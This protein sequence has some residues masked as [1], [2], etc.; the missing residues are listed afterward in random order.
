MRYNP[1]A[2]SRLRDAPIATTQ[3]G[4]FKYSKKGVASVDLSDPYHFAVSLT[5]PRFIALV[6]A[7]YLSLNLIFATTLWLIPGSVGNARPGYFPDYLFFSFETLATVGYGELYPQGDAGH[8]VA[9][10][11]IFC[12]IWFM[13]ILT[14]LVFVRFS[15]P[16]S[17]F[18]IARGPVICM[19][20]NG[21]ALM[22]RLANG[23]VAPLGETEAKL[24]VL[25]AE[26][27]SEGKIFRRAHA[28]KLERAHLPV[29]PLTWTLIHLI[30][31]H[32]PL[33]GFDSDA[34]IAGDAR[35][36]LSLSSYD[37]VLAT[38]LHEGVAFPPKAIMFAMRYQDIVSATEDGSP[39]ADLTRISEV[40]ADPS[41]V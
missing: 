12:G 17:K 22:L 25:L 1:G 32:S 15:R 9:A 13:A 8:L 4:D 7:V 39:M 2:A 33:S 19:H 27:T 20:N 6:V 21:R 5:W 35:L 41:F 18:V 16:K 10:L 14:G 3:S 28:L 23:R 38:T 34:L 11:E 37:P 24:S 29:F 40:E 30:D 31:A 36:F 26:T